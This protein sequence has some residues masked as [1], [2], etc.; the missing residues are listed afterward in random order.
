[1]SGLLLLGKFGQLGWELHRTIA[2]LGDVVALDYP[3]INL[4]NLVSLDEVVVHVKPDIIINAAAYTAVDKAESETES[5]MAIN[6][7]APR[8]MAELAHKFEAA[9]IHFSTDYVFDGTKGSTYHESDTPNPLG[10]YGESKLAGELAIQE[11]DG[12]YL[13]L[14]TSWV[15]SMR[16]DSFVTK[17]LSWAHNQTSLR[18]VDDQISNPT[19]CR[20]LAETTAQLLAKASDH[21][22][23]WINE[24]RGLYH[25][26]GSGYASRF[27][28]AK[29]IIEFDPQREDQKVNDLRPAKTSEFPTPA[30][31][32]LYSALNCDHFKETFSLRLPQWEE[33]LKLAMV[34]G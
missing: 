13:I 15:Y 16:R 23:E 18:I 7:H 12:A 21:P 26:A 8:R 31:R 30:Q 27:E 34:G 20:M 33:A 19:W 3:E 25:L 17:V 6:A 29:K 4:M 5:A 2:P 22:A 1:M 14:R 32:P 28:W 9:F 10:M 24:K 11:V